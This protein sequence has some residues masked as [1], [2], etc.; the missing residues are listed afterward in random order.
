MQA[1][2]KLTDIRGTT[3]KWL[4]YSMH[5]VLHVFLSVKTYTYPWTLGFMKAS[6][7][8]LNA[9]KGKSWGFIMHKRHH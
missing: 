1:G 7:S 3:K 9:D 4:P 5:Y 2:T 8:L 6:L